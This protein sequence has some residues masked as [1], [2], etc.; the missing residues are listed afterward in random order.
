MATELEATLDAI[1]AESSKIA[2][3]LDSF[4]DAVKAFKEA[5]NNAG[6]A[7]SGSWLG[8]QSRV[9]Y[10]GLRP[11]PA[12]AH[13]D[14]SSGLRTRAYTNGTVGDWQ[15]YEYDEIYDRLKSTVDAK[16]FDDLHET[17]N[18]ARESVSYAQDRLISV[19]TAI[20]EKSGSLYIERLIQDAYDA[21]CPNA[22]DLVDAQRPS[23][24]VISRDTVAISNGWQAPPHIG[25]LAVVLAF[26]SPFIVAKKIQKL[27]G[28]AKEHI[29]HRKS[30]TASA[31]QGGNKIFIGH[32]RST[33]WRDLKDFLQDRLMLEWDEFNRVPIAGITNVARLSQM[34]DDASIAFLVMTA[35]DEQ[36][37]GKLHARMN[38]IHEAGLFQ[39]RLGFTR[40]I[41]I[42]EEG[43]ETFSNIDGL[44]QLRFPAGNIASI[45]E[46][47]REILEREG[48]LD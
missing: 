9:Y 10:N 42:L 11:P 33:A 45:F 31:T 7:W 39:G 38:V 6:K 15:E 8:Y 12:G 48:L 17:A 28:R 20:N 2:N 19:L 27:A 41:V 3:G 25:F 47:I 44:G 34:L 30:S 26:E 22:R 4:R 5:A 23:G 13:F 24:A 36:I 43:C 18:K 35:E 29:Q 16:V 32:G 14:P 21:K 37:D 40:S 46:Q 1:A